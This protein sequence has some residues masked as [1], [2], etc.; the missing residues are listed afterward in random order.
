MLQ[1]FQVVH[2][3]LSAIAMRKQL[4]ARGGWSV[5]GVGGLGTE[6][7]R[8]GK[9]LALAYFYPQIFTSFQ[10]FFDL[11]EQGKILARELKPFLT[12]RMQEPLER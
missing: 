4:L 1:V 11:A 7:G 10:F 2:I 3:N 5:E 9:N 6:E 12:L 8:R